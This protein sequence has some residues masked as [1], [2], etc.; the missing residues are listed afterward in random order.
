MCAHMALAPFSA[1][2]KLP[3]SLTPPRVQKVPLSLGAARIF[4]GGR[5][6]RAPAKKK[7]K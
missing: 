2:R 4:K 3:P 5:R 6:I 7:K 1:G